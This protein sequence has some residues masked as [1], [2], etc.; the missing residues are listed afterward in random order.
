MALVTVFQMLERIPDRLAAELVI[1][2]IDWKY[3]LHFP[4]TY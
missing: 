1:S 4:L 3:A 2:R